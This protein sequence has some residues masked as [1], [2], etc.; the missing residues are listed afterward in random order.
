MTSNGSRIT[1]MK[2]LTK[3]QTYVFLC[4][5]ALMVVGAFMSMMRWMAAPYVFCPGALAYVAMQMLQRYVG[6]DFTVKRLR[7]ILLLSDV[8]LLLT[9]LLMLA[10]QGNPLGLDQLTYLRYVHNNWV[11]TLLVAALLQLYAT[12][13]IDQELRKDKKP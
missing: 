13:R 2:E 6:T 10:D 7:R 8:L 1:T 9:G 5:A 12:H 3:V 4:G 11:V